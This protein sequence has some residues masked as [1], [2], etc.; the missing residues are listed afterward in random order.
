MLT[1]DLPERRSPPDQA[2]RSAGSGVVF[3]VIDLDAPD[4]L[5]RLRRYA[6][7]QAG[8]L[9]GFWDQE[10]GAPRLDLENVRA[11]KEH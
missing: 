2:L 9:P 6:M 3:D 7:G 1:T 5:D 11:Q 8:P 4:A 10:L